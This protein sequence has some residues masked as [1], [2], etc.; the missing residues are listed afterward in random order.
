MLS[1]TIARKSPLFADI[2][3]RFWNIIPPTAK[4]VFLFFFNILIL[5]NAAVFKVKILRLKLKP[6]CSA[7]TVKKLDTMVGPSML[8]ICA[9]LGASVS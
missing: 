2:V 9:S 6:F 5:V 3:N 1:D 4:T 8:M 7:H